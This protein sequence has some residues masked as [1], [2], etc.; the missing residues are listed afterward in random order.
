VTGP[1]PWW[2]TWPELLDR[3]FS[4]LR[5]HNFEYQVDSAAKAAGILRLDLSVV[6][7]GRRLQ[8][9]ATYPDLYPYFRFEVQAPAES[10]PYHQHALGKN[11]CL[12]GRSTEA[13]SITDTLGQVLHEQLPKLLDS[14]RV[15]SADEVKDQEE[16]QGEPYSDYYPYVPGTML[17]VDGSWRIP[18]AVTAGVLL[19]GLEPPDDVR[20]P[21]VRGA[22]LEVRD[23]RSEVLARAHPSIL[24]TRKLDKIEARWLRV[25]S[26]IPAGN[27]R[28]FLEAVQKLDPRA[29]SNRAHPM[30][31]MTG[32]RIW[33][34]LF[35]EEVGWRR[36][37]WGW[38]FGCIVS[39]LSGGSSGHVGRQPAQPLKGRRR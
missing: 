15:A 7:A 33:G 13:W 4:S 12:M 5:Q 10:F 38:V 37:G 26:P 14:A 24:G 31:G 25:R 29:S 3:E 6:I 2:E 17:L 9:R 8:L 34:V 16:H 23:D 11:L 36:G 18:E 35:P 27:P 19:I 20:R 28:D 22:I 30:A 32:L 21:V 1:R 39:E